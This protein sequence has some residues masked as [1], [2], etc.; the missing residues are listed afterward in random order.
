MPLTSFILALWVVLVSKLVI[1]GILSSIFLILALYT[2]FLTTSFLL[3]HLVY[4]YQQ[5]QVLIYQHQIY[6]LYFSNCSNHL[7]H[8]SVYQ[9]LILSTS[10]FK[11]AKSVIFTQDDVSTLVAFLKSVFVPYLDKSN[12]TFTFAPKEFGFG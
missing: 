7:I 10:D 12:S 3:H 9:Y 6:L 2:S 5:E 1:S 8:F 4:L 11:L